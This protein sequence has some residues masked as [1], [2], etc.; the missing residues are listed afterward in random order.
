MTLRDG[1][2]EGR[3]GG[4]GLPLGL[5]LRS[6]GSKGGTDLHRPLLLSREL[7]CLPAGEV[8][9]SAGGGQELVDTHGRGKIGQISNV[10]GFGIERVVGA[11]GVWPS[12]HCA[13]PGGD[14]WTSSDG[15]YLSVVAVCRYGLPQLHTARGP[16]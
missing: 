1:V 8:P 10:F 5:C 15:D 11:V 2:P 6:R 12:P 3:G 14:C 9:E 7:P 13:D 16:P 4:R